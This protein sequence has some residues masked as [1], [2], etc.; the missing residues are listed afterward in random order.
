[1][2]GD[3]EHEHRIDRVQ[4]RDDGDWEMG[5]EVLELDLDLEQEAPPD[6]RMSGATQERQHD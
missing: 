4:R 1:M 6:Q 2:D 3:P 5:K